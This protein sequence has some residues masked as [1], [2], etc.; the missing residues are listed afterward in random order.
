[1]ELLILFGKGNQ[2]AKKKDEGEWGEWDEP[3]ER[4]TSGIFGGG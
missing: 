4:Q 3:N 2:A 1:L